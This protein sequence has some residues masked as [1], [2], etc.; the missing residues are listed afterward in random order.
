[1]GSLAL[2]ALESALKSDDLAV[3][4]GNTECLRFHES[5]RGQSYCRNSSWL[6]ERHREDSMIQQ[7]APQALD[8]SANQAWARAENQSILMSCSSWRIASS[9]HGITLG[10]FLH[11]RHLSPG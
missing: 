2:P 11:G 3:I 8:A 10:S 4:H 9:I 1:M 6:M 7:A 5:C